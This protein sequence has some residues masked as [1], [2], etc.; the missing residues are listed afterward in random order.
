MLEKAQKAKD[1]RGT[2][3]RLWGYLSQQRAALIATTL[4]VI[5]STLLNLL[6]PYLMG[7]AIDQYIITRDL[8]GWRGCWPGWW[9]RM[10]PPRSLPIGRLM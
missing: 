1:R 10:P 3:R 8:A 5:V 9:R 4:M 6:G 2:L 7:V